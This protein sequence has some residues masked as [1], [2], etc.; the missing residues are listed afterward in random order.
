MN[1]DGVAGN[2]LMFIPTADQI[3]TMKFENYTLAGVTQTQAM[4]QKLLK[5]SL[6]KIN[7]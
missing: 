7:I 5:I 4:Q 3:S 1:G 6:A 2:D